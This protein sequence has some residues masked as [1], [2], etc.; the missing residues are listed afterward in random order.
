MGKPLDAWDAAYFT[1]IGVS[2]ELPNHYLKLTARENLNYFR[3]LYGEAAVRPED[4]LAEVGLLD[5]ID[6]PVSAFS[7]GM[8]NRLNVARS[9]LHQ[10]Q[11]WFLDEPTAG[12][13][14]VNARNIRDL[15]DARRKA[16]TT[17]F[18]TTHD[19]SVADALCDRV[20]F[21]VDGHLDPDR[22]LLYTS[23]GLAQAA[24]HE[25]VTR[26]SSSAWG[27]HRCGMRCHR[28]RR[29]C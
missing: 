6:K 16:G 10:P 18:L 29:C 23:V 24:P 11:L 9:M 26:F 14:P 19:M 8:K 27:G 28:C 25:S 2:F 1:K 4:V 17:V 21:M 22:L 7:K 12:L 13:D 20:G 15:V 5:D 3:A